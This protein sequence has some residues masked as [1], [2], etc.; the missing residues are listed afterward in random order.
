MLAHGQTKRNDNADDSTDIKKGTYVYQP[1]ATIDAPK[2]MELV[3]LLDGQ[4]ATT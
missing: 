4:S 1:L 3:Q 2:V